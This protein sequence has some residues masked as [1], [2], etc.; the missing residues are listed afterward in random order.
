MQFRICQWSV[1]T[2]LQIAERK[3][4]FL[5]AAQARAGQFRAFAESADLP[6]A[7]F[8]DRDEKA[9]SY[10]LRAEAAQLREMFSGRRFRWAVKGTAPSPLCIR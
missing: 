7:A 6:V 2:R 3:R 4:P 1:L 8:V 5:H 10:R 9:R